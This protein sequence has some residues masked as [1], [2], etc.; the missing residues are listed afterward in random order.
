MSDDAVAV[1]QKLV[2]GSGVYFL[3]FHGCYW[4]CRGFFAHGFETFRKIERDKRGYW[5][6]S[7][8][9]SF[10]AALIC[11]LSAQILWKDPRLIMPDDFFFATPESR[12]VLQVFLGYIWS[13]LMLTLYYRKRWPGWMENIFHHLCIMATWS[14]FILTGCGQAV[15]TVSHL[16]ELTTPFVNQRWF[17]AEAGMKS[18]STYFYNGIAM[19]VLW[20][21]TRILL[22]SWA[23]LYLFKCLPQLQT[24]GTPATSVVISCYMA[25]LTLQYFW[26]YKIVRGALKSLKKKKTE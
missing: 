25:G 5:C 8:V 1:L 15:A 4:S 6:S 26:F 12:R 16:C 11:A 23:G 10:H 2:R 18:T 24:L 21:V 13:D 3:F 17:L 20:F 14:I 19:L 9:S 7:M 22:Y